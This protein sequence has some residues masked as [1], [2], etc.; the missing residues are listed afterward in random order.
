MINL[1][2]T[3]KISLRALRVN[4]MRS[5][6]TMLGIIIGVGAVI[7]MLAV[8][9]GASNK[10][11]EQIATVGS[12]LIMVMPGSAGKRGFHGPRGSATTLI[13]EDAEAIMRECPSV[14]MVT[15]IVRSSGQAVFGNKNWQTSIMGSNESY[16]KISSREIEHGRFFTA[17]ES[18]SG[19]KV[20]VVGSTVVENLFGNLN[21]I[22]QTIRFKKLP[23]TVVGVL[24][25]R[26]ET[27]MGSDQDDLILVPFFAIQRRIL[28][29][30]HAHM[31]NISA[32]TPELV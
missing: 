20:C 26:G 11:S 6:L 22:G 13:P 27:S 28:G 31:L 25:D 1:P 32:R 29:I 15:P 5:A 30:S 23:L 12:N 24:K 19:Q 3:I 4:K 17:A 7:T 21:P 2:S 16:L 9:K 8:G 10:I 18:R 14:G